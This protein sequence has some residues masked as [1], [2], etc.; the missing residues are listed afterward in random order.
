MYKIKHGLI[1][2]ALT[3]VMAIGALPIGVFADD[4]PGSAQGT[5]TVNFTAPKGDQLILNKVPSFDFGSHDLEADGGKFTAQGDEYD[6][7]NLTGNDNGYTVTAL[8]SALTTADGKNTL[9]FGE[10]GLS[11]KTEDG[12]V[13]KLSGGQITGTPDFVKISEKANTVATG[14]K[15]SNGELTSGK[16][17]ATLEISKVGTKSQTYNGTID[18]TIAAN[19]Q[20]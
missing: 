20:P 9:D 8:A 17:S 6:V 18:Y 19:V 12:A 4:T 1:G 10:T 16:T 13:D 11:T 2:V 3:S 14:N 7:T 15:N 5:T